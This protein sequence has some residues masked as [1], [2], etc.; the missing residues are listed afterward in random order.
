MARSLHP[1]HYLGRVVEVDGAQISN[2][3]ELPHRARGAE[4]TE[5]LWGHWGNLQ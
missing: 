1:Q 3:D 2:T 5:K 4:P